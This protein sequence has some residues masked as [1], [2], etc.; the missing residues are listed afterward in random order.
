MSTEDD[1]KQ[2]QPTSKR[3]EELRESGQILRSKDLSSGFIL[4]IAIATIMFISGFLKTRFI[5]NFTQTFSSINLVVNDPE[6]MYKIIRHLFYANVS[7]LLPIFIILILAAFG[8]AFLLGGWNFTFSALK[9]DWNRINPGTNLGNIYSKKLFA[10]VAKSTM[11]FGIIAFFF[12][13]F[14]TSNEKQLLGLSYLEYNSSLNSLAILIHD[15][16]IMIFM[17]IIIIVAADIIHSYFTYQQR[18]MM[19]TQE[20]KDEHKNT[21]GN[22]DVKRKMRSLQY[23]LLKQKIPQMVPVA[24]VIITNPSHYAVAL[25]YKEGK[26]KAPK[27]IAKGKGSVAQYIKKLAIAS[28]V[29]IYEEPPLARAIYHTTKT[30]TE[31]NPELYI[32]VAIVLT[33]I[34]QLRRYQSGN[35]PLP[36]KAEALEIPPHFQFKG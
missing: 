9:F 1:Q 31:I 8:S 34:N 36:I 23:A 25:Q 2:H 16:I 33:Y 18:T 14:I 5:D 7:V 30:G 13:Y 20:L 19:S 26:D 17:A 29:P 35:G 3:L 21:E 12:W 32:A 22:A 27:V 24:N 4:A 10:D 15:F 28:G 6:Q 11:K